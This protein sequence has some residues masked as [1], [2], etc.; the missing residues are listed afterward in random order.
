MP[1]RWGLLLLLA[2]LACEHTEAPEPAHPVADTLPD[3]GPPPRLTLNAEMDLTP[4]Y[5]PDGNALWYAWE[6]NDQ[7]DRDVCLG[8]L[9]IGGG[10]RSRETCR[11]APGSVGDSVNWLISPAPHPDG[12]RVAWYQL[13][14]R[15]Q[16][17]GSSGEIV[18]GPVDGINDPSR[19]TGLQHFPINAPSGRTH[20]MPEQLQWANDSTL[21]YLA[22][23]VTTNDTLAAQ[24][25][26]Y[27]G[28]EIATLTLTGDTATLRSI[29]GTGLASGVAV[30]P[31]GKIVF[32]RNGD[33]R[34][35]RTTLTGGPVE[36]IHDFGN[37]SNF[38]RDPVVAGD[39][40][41]A[42]VAGEIS[43]GT[44]PIVG[45]LQLDKGGELWRG[46]ANS[47]TLISRD[48]L[49]R[50]PTMAPDHRTVAMEGRDPITRIQDIYLVNISG[51]R[52]IPPYTGPGRPIQ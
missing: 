4:A 20:V 24:D 23:L 34:I 42:I 6:R 45:P 33:P 22:V 48:R 16:S 39:T 36:T 30:A 8:L 37:I 38:A 12:Q 14:S 41:Y 17:R 26:F 32:T 51:T 47:S 18:L 5:T 10:P 27:S 7:S 1:H 44:Y 13:S 52:S 46:Y 19:Y 11:L 3:D 25:T 21:V 50:H 43:Y 40:I 2:I 29:P 15:V 31:N 35:Y 9:P 49:F 28:L